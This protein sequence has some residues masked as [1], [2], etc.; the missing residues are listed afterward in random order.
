[1]DFT[2]IFKYIALAKLHINQIKPVHQSNWQ[3]LT[4]Y[5][6]STYVYFTQSEGF[7]QL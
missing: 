7:T 2:W 3:V 5:Y 6:P 4:V 1:M